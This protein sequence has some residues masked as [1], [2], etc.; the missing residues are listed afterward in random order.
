MTS[1]AELK[2]RNEIVTK[3]ETLIN[4][5]KRILDLVSDYKDMAEAQV[6]IVDAGDAAYADRYK[7]DLLRDIT[8]LIG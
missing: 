3:D 7:T 4:S 5:K 8:A 1:I 6:A 2:K